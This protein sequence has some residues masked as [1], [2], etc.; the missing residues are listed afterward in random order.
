MGD[1]ADFIGY[2]SPDPCESEE[3]KLKLYN[4]ENLLCYKD[5]TIYKECKQIKI[6]DDYEY[7][8]LCEKILQHYEKYKKLTNNQK[9]ALCCLLDEEGFCELE[10]E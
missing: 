10:G 2:N 8:D 9:Y 4:V 6:K 5:E 7:K 3:I 1:M